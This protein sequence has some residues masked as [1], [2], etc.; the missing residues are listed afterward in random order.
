MAVG[1]APSAPPAGASSLCGLLDDPDT[2][3]LDILTHPSVVAA[4]K[5]NDEKLS[6][7]L[8]GSDGA[9]PVIQL[10]RTTADRT[11]AA[12]VT[13]L[14]LSSNQ[15]LALRLFDNTDIIEAFSQL[16][17]RHEPSQ[18]FAIGCVAQ[19]LSDA[20]LR[21]QSRLFD[22]L[23]AAPTFWSSMLISIGLDSVFWGLNQL[24]RLSS[25]RDRGFLWGY[26]LALLGRGSTMARP[27][28]EWCVSSPA[29]ANAA[30]VV[31]S[32][33][34]RSKLIQ[35]FRFYVLSYPE[36]G[37][38]VRN[39]V[40]ECR[41]IISVLLTDD[42]VAEFFRLAVLL[43]RQQAVVD[44]A[45]ASL[46][47]SPMELGPRHEQAVWYLC[48]HF[49]VDELHVIVLFVFET[50]ILTHVNQFIFQSIRTLVEGVLEKIESP[51]LFLKAMQHAIACAW[52]RKGETCPLLKRVALL[53][54]AALASGSPSFEGW[55]AFQ[56]A[57]VRPYRKRECFPINFQ[58]PEDGMDDTLM[59]TLW[60]ADEGVRQDRRSAR[61]R[62]SSA[63]HVNMQALDLGFHRRDDGA[64]GSRIEPKRASDEELLTPGA[65]IRTGP[66]RRRPKARL[67][68]K[69]KKKCWVA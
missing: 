33:R 47:L 6:V 19:I 27:P 25:E 68:T 14:F 53:E 59:A 67:S 13:A 7:R 11:V 46:F 23:S 10:F 65:E 22:Q 55:V 18:T 26:F 21:F 16:L 39:F 2:P 36:N 54:L 66:T 29:V 3:L 45:V 41:L 9:C 49:D 20:A 5:G 15:T 31:L 4:F 44:L 50:L 30:A 37:S 8:L 12:A 57:V 42:E 24:V 56:A 40:L 32:P 58:I 1:D 43:P 35:M 48:E 60:G 51:Q 28:P 38:F 34:E 62:T 52:N 63:D 69:P 61:P 17:C 64:R